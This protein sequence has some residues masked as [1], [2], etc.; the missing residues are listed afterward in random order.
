M[1]F[2]RTLQHLLPTGA[3]WRTTVES[4]LRSFFE[5]LGLTYDAA[6]AYVDDVYDDL[7][8]WRTRQLALWERQFGLPGAGSE[9]DRR[10]ALAAAWK[11]TGG[12][13]PAYLQGVMQAA[14]FDVYIHEWWSSGPPFVARDPRDYTSQPLIGSHRCGRVQERCGRPGVTCNRYLANEVGYLVNRDLTRNAPPPVPSDPARW[15]YFLYWGGETFG[16]KA[17]IPAERRAEF[18]Q[19]LLRICPAQQW[20]VTMVEYIPEGETLVTVNGKYVVVDGKFLVV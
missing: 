6:R 10:R 20:L 19:L 2:F 18:E 8:P 16:A 13:A 1:S 4:T 7:D 12:Q 3:A 14:G 15:P 5:G 9:T 11:A 17:P